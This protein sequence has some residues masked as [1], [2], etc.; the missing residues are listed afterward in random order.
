MEIF[1]Q[2]NFNFVGN[3]KIVYLISLALLLSGGVSLILH[4]GPNWGIDFTGGALVQLKFPEPIAT[5]EIRQLLS[6]NGIEKSQIQRVS[7]TNVAII[8]VKE[9]EIDP[10]LTG[11]KLQEIFTT[12]LTENVPIVERNEMV[13]PVVGAYLIKLGLKAFVLAFLGIIIYVAIRFKGTTWGITAVVALLHDFFIVFGLLSVFNK[14][15]TLAVVAALLTLIGYSVNDTIVIFVR[16]REHLR[17]RLKETFEESIN[18]GINETLPRTV[19]TSVTTLFVALALFIFGGEIIHDFAFVMVS[20]IIA[21]T[22]SSVCISG[23]LV[24]DWHR[25]GQSRSPKGKRR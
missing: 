16:I 1:K 5:A 20:G 18:R 12:Q 4:G 19:I 23:S 21:G 3:R 6:Q 10:S 25:L 15:I 2:P 8:R 24:Y 22:Y 14:E 11:E 13:G 17:L 7:R 9:A